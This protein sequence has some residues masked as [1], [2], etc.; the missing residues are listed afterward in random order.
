MCGVLANYGFH[1]F[2]FF[3]YI[4]DLKVGMENFQKGGIVLDF[5]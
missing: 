4:P 1:Q 3:I 5:K 2:D